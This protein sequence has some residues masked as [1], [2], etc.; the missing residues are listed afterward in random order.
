M[1]THGDN[2]Y[3]HY[4]LVD[5]HNTHTHLNT[6]ADWEV[7]RN[8]HTYYFQDISS[9]VHIR[10]CVHTTRNQCSLEVDKFRCS[11]VGIC[12]FDGMHVS[13]MGLMGLSRKG[14]IVVNTFVYT[15]YLH[16][17]RK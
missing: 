15:Q 16:Y 12:H 1:H 9:I 8:V 17:I 3:K 14:L 5:T 11:S 6:I 4:H 13:L 10:T 7:C 2:D